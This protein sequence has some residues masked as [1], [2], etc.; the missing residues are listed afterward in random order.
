MTGELRA[1]QMTDSELLLR[2]RS[3]E[4][5]F[6]RRVRELQQAE[7]DMFAHHSQESL[8][9]MKDTR[10]ALY[11]GRDRDRLGRFRNADLTSVNYDGAHRDRAVRIYRTA[12]TA[13]KARFGAAARS[14]R[15]GYSAC[16]HGKLFS[17][18]RPSCRSQ[19]VTRSIGSKLARKRRN[20][21]AY[22]GAGRSS[23]S[24]GHPFASGTVFAIAFRC[25]PP[26][27]QHPSR[28]T[29]PMSNSGIMTLR[30]C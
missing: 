11:S 4:S 13:L 30:L 10:G 14:N 26:S 12:I 21:S 16:L 2:Y 5:E 19:K 17:Q 22:W 1:A 23:S 15:S 18:L 8:R 9:G 24:I 28:S 20:R 7:A 3:A 25:L 27:A 29:T 6:E